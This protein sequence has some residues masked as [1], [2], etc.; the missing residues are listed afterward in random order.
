MA[1]KPEKGVLVE[2]NLDIRIKRKKKSSKAPS[3]AGRII[4]T[5]I[6]IAAIIAIIYLLTS[7]KKVDVSEKQN[8]TILK[9]ITEQ[10]PY[11]ILEEYDE[12]I[13][14]GPPKCGNTIMNF[15]ASDPWMHVAA[16]SSVIC[17]FNL[18]NLE[19][20]EGTWEY[21]AYIQGITGNRYDKETVGANSTKTFSFIFE[22]YVAVTSGCGISIVSL[23]S[24]EKCVFPKETFYQ[25]VH[26]TRNVTKYRNVTSEKQVPVYNETTVTKSLNRFFGYPI[27]DFG[28]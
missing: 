19:P 18:T 1:K 4:R 27:I 21:M 8:Y 28:W 11:I 10:Q 24:M 15:T 14:L 5:A 9:K 22:P 7:T 23:P 16:N 17:A 6:Y 13:P 12:T 3:R 25:V 26:K 20:K 2:S